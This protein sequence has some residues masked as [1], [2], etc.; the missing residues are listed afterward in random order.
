MLG[1]TLRFDYEVRSEKQYFA[2]VPSPR[3]TRDMI[4]MASRILD[5]KNTKFDPK[6][7]KDE[8]ETALKK[9]VRRKSK[10]HTIEIEE[11]AKES[12]NVINLMDALRQSVSSKARGA[13]KRKSTRRKAA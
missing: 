2:H 5:S 4:E 9:L 1:T 12:S 10:G 3:V 13:K 11:P 8:Y 7:F 6:K